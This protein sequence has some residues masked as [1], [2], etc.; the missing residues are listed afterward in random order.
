MALA[1]LL[2]L[3]WQLLGGRQQPQPQTFPLH[4]PAA[5]D[6]RYPDVAI[7]ARYLAMPYQAR[8]VLL[9]AH[10]QVRQRKVR[11]QSLSR[12]DAPAESDARSGCAHKLT[13]LQLWQRQRQARQLSMTC[14][15]EG[16]LLPCYVKMV[17]RVLARG[18][19]LPQWPPRLQVQLLIFL[20][21]LPRPPSP[22]LKQQPRHTRP[23]SW[24]RP[25]HP[26]HPLMMLYLLAWQRR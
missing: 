6:A 17:R 21:V 12:S 23:R 10:A 14:G 26:L 13:M 18:L 1:C 22:P 25:S 2:L 16:M 9:G 24:R 4:A 20:V 8:V 15:A 19:P 11:V 5:A 3:L 7:A